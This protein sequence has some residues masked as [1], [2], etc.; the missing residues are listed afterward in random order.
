MRYIILL[1]IIAVS[2]KQISTSIPRTHLQHTSSTQRDSQDTS[3]RNTP[4]FTYRFSEYQYIPSEDDQDIFE[5]Y[6]TPQTNKYIGSTT[7][8]TDIL[9]SILP[10]PS[11]EIS[12]S[13]LSKY[14]RRTRSIITR[15]FNR[16]FLFFCCQ[17][18]K[19][20]VG[21]RIVILSE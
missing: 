12:E 4:I 14:I 1:G 8:L 2:L 18:P 11:E 20:M 17:V 13:I 9:T 10:N 7:M 5:Y 3:A 15:I 21:P 16:I 19:Q 6:N